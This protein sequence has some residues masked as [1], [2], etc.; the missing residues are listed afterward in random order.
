MGL[1][2]ATGAL[3][4]FFGPLASNLI[5]GAT[6]IFGSHAI[7]SPFYLA[8]LVV[9]PAILLALSAGRAVKTAPVL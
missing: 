6:F 9:A 5:F 8:A 3:A 7:E 4:R 2:N 1:N